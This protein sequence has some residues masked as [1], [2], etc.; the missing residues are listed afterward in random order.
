MW[1]RIESSNIQVI[2][3]LKL[4]EAKNIISGGQENMSIAPH[5]IF[6]RDKKNFRG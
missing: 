2:N 3:Q 5:S 4:G 1:V 6:Y